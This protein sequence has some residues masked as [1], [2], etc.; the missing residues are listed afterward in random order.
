LLRSHMERLL[1]IAEAEDRRAFR[2]EKGQ[3][4]GHDD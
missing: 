4:H 2:A 1:E 3:A